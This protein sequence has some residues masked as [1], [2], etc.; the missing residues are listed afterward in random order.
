MELQMLITILL[1]EVIISFILFKND[2]IAPA[3]IF[4]IV[5]LIAALNVKSNEDYWKVKINSTTVT[6]I[7]GGVAFFIL[8]C[9][10]VQMFRIGTKLIANTQ[11]NR[12]VEFRSINID[13]N[14]LILFMVYYV[15]IDVLMI[16]FIRSI[17]IQ[18]G[19]G[20]SL[21]DLIG[22]YNKL[23]KENSVSLPLLLNQFIAICIWMGYVWLYILINNYFT[24]KKI[25]KKVLVLFIMTCICS[26]ITGSRGDLI[27]MIVCGIIM[28]V[29]MVRKKN[30]DKIFKIPLKALIIVITLVLLFLVLF[31]KVGDFLG[32]DAYLYDSHE[33]L[34][35]YVGGPLLNLNNCIARGLEKADVWGQETFIALNN[36][37]GNFIGNANLQYGS[38]RTF[39]GANYHNTGNVCTTFYDYYFDFGVVGC[40]MIAFLTGIFVQFIYNKARK[41]MAKTS[42]ISISVMFF[43]YI[44]FLTARSFFA[45]SLIHFVFGLQII[46]MLF[47]WMLAKMFLEKIRIKI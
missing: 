2:L 41:T 12:M 40:F 9:L 27:A 4:S 10:I 31:Q 44:L 7:G 26:L 19:G 5:F 14:F 35:I 16:Y 29:M 36:M 20:G 11:E 46:K 25:N 22:Y 13:N 45:N 42:G 34:S 24:D 6:I 39:Y 37:I 8:G 17:A 15:I 38:T 3:F 33:Y 23:S 1:I 43:S 32:R 28:Y 21:F 18:Y 30:Q 47:I